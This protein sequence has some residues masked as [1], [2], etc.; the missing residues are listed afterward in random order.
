MKVTGWRW[1]EFWL[2]KTKSMTIFKSKSPLPHTIS[3]TDGTQ[4]NEEGVGGGE[5]FTL[6]VLIHYRKAEAHSVTLSPW[7]HLRS[8]R[9]V[10]TSLQRFEQEMTHT[11]AH[12]RARVH[13][14]T[15]THCNCAFMEEKVDRP[16]CFPVTKNLL[17]NRHKQYSY[18]YCTPDD[19]QHQACNPSLCFWQIFY[20]ILENNDMN[21]T[22]T[23]TCREFVAFKVGQDSIISTSG[24]MTFPRLNSLL[25]VWL[26]EWGQV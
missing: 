5:V 1:F 18:T 15:Q 3:K 13:A 26:S 25:S 17:L 21:S 20:F 7:R 19:V 12:V 22:S 14:P 2:A 10:T 23:F 6:R 8:T 4:N 16:I 9:K 11:H 24:I